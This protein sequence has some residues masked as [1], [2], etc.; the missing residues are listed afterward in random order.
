MSFV[1]LV[2]GSVH[3]AAPALVGW[4]LLVDGVGGRIVEVEAY[5]GRGDRA[6]HAR[7]GLTRRTATMFGPPGR[8]YIYLVYGLHS[9]LNVVTD[10]DGTPGAVLIRALEPIEGEALMR[11]R[12]ARGTGRPSRS[13]SAAELC[14]GP[15]NLTRALGISLAQNRYDLTRGPLRIEDRRLAARQVAWTPRIGITVGVHAPWRAIAVGSDAVSGS[16]RR[17]K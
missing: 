2:G 6:S 4:T 8:A 7:A 17:A 10:R 9:C 15:G 12:R 14:R 3:D 11:R 5:D 13:V 1:E 16:R